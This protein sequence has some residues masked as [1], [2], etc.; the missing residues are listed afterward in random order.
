[1]K[2]NKIFAATIATLLSS[3]LPSVLIE[4]VEGEGE[5]EAVVWEEAVVA[6]GKGV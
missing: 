3:P 6:G 2:D 1:M 5:E 4:V